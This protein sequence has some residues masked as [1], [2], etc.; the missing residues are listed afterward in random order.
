VSPPRFLYFD[1]GNVLVSF[2]VERY[3]RQLG[4]VAC[5]DPDTVHQ[6]IFGG[7]LQTEYELGRISSR[8]FYDAFCRETKTTPDFHAL[9]RAGGDIFELKPGVVSLVGEL[10]RAGHRMGILSNTCE[11]HWEHCLHRFAIL[12]EAFERYALSFQIGAMKPEPAM[13][14][15]AAGL[16]GVQPHEVF[17]TDDTPGHVAGARA[18]G[19]DAVIFASAPQLAE[20]LRSRGL[21]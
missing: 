21:L 18:A 20:E 13:F 14:V 16:A 3:C 8:A 11:M 17:F 7:G 1:L 9:C 10:R 12:R 19:F 5:L 6:V 15:A 4:E 2:T